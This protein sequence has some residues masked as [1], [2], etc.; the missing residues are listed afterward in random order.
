MDTETHTL[1]KAAVVLNGA[2]GALLGRTDTSS[3]LED[4]LRAAGFAPEFIPP[5]FGSIQ[6]RMKRACEIAP[7]LIVGGGDGTIA[8]GAQ[9]AYAT[10]TI[11]GILPLGTMNVLAIDLGIPVGN[12]A[13]AV[14][15]LR[16]NPVREIDAASVNGQ[17]YLCH[18]WIGLPA[19]LGRYRE[20]GRGKGSLIRLWY[21]VARAALRV[22][23]RY[24]SPRIV[25]SVDGVERK[26]HA[27]ALT[28][29]PNLLNDAS[30]R[31]LGR[32]RMDAG[33]LGV[34]AIRHMNLM[35]MLKLA[36]RALIG[37]K[38]PDLRSSVAKQAIVTRFG[39]RS[40]K[41]IRVMSDGEVF[42]MRPP[43]TY[44]ILPRAI[45]IIAPPAK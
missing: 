26:T 24:G 1:K 30:G 8:C 41:A 7:I 11:L 2:S 34:Y 27:A 6:Q 16:D 20:A 28:V 12:V 15:V 9:E 35:A 25:L 37:R 33:V 45:R 4:L 13:A 38:D 23:A 17:I 36:F 21:R 18:S 32:E 14:A 31:L 39:R 40:R 5:Q 29:T 42:L 44:R 43:L 3:S 19:R 22:S 10:G